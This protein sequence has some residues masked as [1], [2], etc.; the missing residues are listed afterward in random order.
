MSAMHLFSALAL[1]ALVG[2]TA[3]WLWPASADQLH[4]RILRVSAEAGP[5]EA[6][7]DIDRFLSRYPA[8]PRAAHIQLLR[9]DIESE[10]LQKQLALRELTSGGSQLRPYQQLWL[11]AIRAKREHPG[12][13]RAMFQELLVQYEGAAD[14]PADL[15]ECLN[16]ARHQ[17][18]RLGQP[19]DSEIRKSAN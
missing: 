6:R 5:A 13:A 19:P 12:E 7:A 9:R 1:S 16:A 10:S 11:R 8:D 2:V 3:W 14:K 4:A 17:L 15:I 18:H